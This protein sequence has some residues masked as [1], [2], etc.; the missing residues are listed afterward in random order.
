MDEFKSNLNVNLRPY[1]EINDRTLTQRVLD[2]YG[3]AIMKLMPFCQDVQP[4][5]R[6]RVPI[7]KFNWKLGDFLC[8]LT[9]N[10]LYVY[11]LRLKISYF[12]FFSRFLSERVKKWRRFYGFTVSWMIVYVRYCLPYVIGRNRSD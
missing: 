1:S 9:T 12:I 5:L 11:F 4:I 10:N 8:D 3:E 2:V 6:A 7:I